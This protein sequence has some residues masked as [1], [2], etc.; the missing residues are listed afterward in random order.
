[1]FC[2]E[3]RI[4]LA[5][6]PTDEWEWLALAQHHG[7]PTR[8]LDWTY[9]PLVGIYFSVESESDSLADGKLFALHAPTQAS[10]RV[11]ASSPFLIKEPVKLYPN[12]VSP[13]IRA[14][15]GLFVACSELETPL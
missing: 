2:R 7:L 13:R 11:R 6:L 3:A 1:M 12:I 15:E 8:L 9:N 4:Q 5:V 14:Q 10:P